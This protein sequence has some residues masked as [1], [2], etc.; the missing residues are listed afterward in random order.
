MRQ[1]MDIFNTVAVGN[2]R[3]WAKAKCGFKYLAFSRVK[4]NKICGIFT[5]WYGTENW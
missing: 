1:K 2:G 3:M 4:N 5:E